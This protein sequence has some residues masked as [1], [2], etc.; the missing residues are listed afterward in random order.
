ME[1]LPSAVPSEEA[2]VLLTPCLAEE[3]PVA[4]CH[5]LVSIVLE[6]SQSAETNI[7]SLDAAA[8][9]SHSTLLLSAHVGFGKIQGG[10]CKLP[11]PSHPPLLVVDL[12][13]IPI[14]ASLPSLPSPK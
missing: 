11:A 12:F 6:G 9:L 1:V 10:L 13:R 2:P 8:P 4:E 7:M 5:R 3:E 14:K